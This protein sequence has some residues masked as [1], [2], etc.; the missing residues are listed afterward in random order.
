MGCWWR[1]QFK[2]RPALTQF[3]RKTFTS[4]SS[5]ISLHGDNFE[6]DGTGTDVNETKM[7]LK[8]A[9][10]TC[11]Q[12]DAGNSVAISFLFSSL[13]IVVISV[14][15]VQVLARID[16]IFISVPYF[17][18]HFHRCLSSPSSSSFSSFF[19]CCPVF[20]LCVHH[21]HKLRWQQPSVALTRI[22]Y[23]LTRLLRFNFIHF[24]GRQNHVY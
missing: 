13:D 15:G 21:L 11:Q 14:E 9:Q 22:S 19:G 12:H 17:L 4:S 20:T 3:Y 8:Q 5:R 6:N 24:L 2:S 18:I 10:R 23:R 7:T 16:E 1:W